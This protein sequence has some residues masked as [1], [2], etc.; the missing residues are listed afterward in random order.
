MK[1][2]FNFGK[3]LEGESMNADEAYSVATYNEVVTQET[4]VKRFLDTTDQLIKAKSENNY[5]SLVM[6]LNDDVAKAKD[7]ILKYYEDKR[8]FVKVIDKRRISWLSWRISIH[9]LEEVKFLYS[10]ITTGIIESEMP[11]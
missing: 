2:I 4:L 5:F 9:I 7:E 3:L 1:N 8:F 6:D 10:N 11:V